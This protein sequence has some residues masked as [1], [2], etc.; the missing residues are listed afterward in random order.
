MTNEVGT[1]EIRHEKYGSYRWALVELLTEWPHERHVRGCS[2]K[3]GAELLRDLYEAD[4]QESVLTAAKMWYRYE[5]PRM[6]KK[7]GTDAFGHMSLEC[8]SIGL[9]PHHVGADPVTG[10][11]L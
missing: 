3:K 4:N 5:W 11:P 6:V 9:L 1:F 8:Q 2:T 7:Y 10:V